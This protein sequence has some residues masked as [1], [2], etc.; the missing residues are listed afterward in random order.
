MLLMRST[1]ILQLFRRG[2]TSEGLLYCS[3]RR[4]IQANPKAQQEPGHQRKELGLRLLSPH[5]AMETLISKVWKELDSGAEA[6][7]FA[8]LFSLRPYW[9]CVC[10][11]RL[12]RYSACNS[13]LN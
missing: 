6:S 4:W 10:A 7:P 9:C 2:G 1:I 11:R 5:P 13:H 12:R 3:R 8:A